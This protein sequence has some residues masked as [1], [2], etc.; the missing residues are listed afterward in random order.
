[1]QLGFHGSYSLNI[2]FALGLVKYVQSAL[3]LIGNTD[4]EKEIGPSM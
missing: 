3:K 1:M 2:K 4:F